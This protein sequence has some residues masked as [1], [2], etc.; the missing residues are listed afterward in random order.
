MVIAIVKSLCFQ[1]ARVIGIR[2]KRR[3]SK[4]AEMTAEILELLNSKNANIIYNNKG[5]VLSSRCIGGN[6]SCEIL[7]T[8]ISALIEQQAAEIAKKD[9][10]LRL[11]ETLRKEIKAFCENLRNGKPQTFHDIEK[12]IYWL[13]KEEAQGAE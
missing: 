7:L 11:A 1:A 6:P 13:E 4:M 8:E 2:C 12:A 3:I 5:A 9:R 10:A